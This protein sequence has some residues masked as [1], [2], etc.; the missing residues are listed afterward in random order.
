MVY[1]FQFGYHGPDGWDAV[2]DDPDFDFES[3]GMLKVLAKSEDEATSW[4]I[5]VAKWYTDKI[6]SADTGYTWSEHLYAIWLTKECPPDE[7][8][9]KIQVIKVGQYPNFDALKEFQ[10]D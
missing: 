1:F 10:N 5:N 3:T 4:G 7:D 2:K 6:H 8:E 9:S